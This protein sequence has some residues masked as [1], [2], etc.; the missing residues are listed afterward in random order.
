VGSSIW[1]LFDSRFFGLR[2]RTKGVGDDAGK[3]SKMRV[4]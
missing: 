1:D 2:G 3:I 4:E